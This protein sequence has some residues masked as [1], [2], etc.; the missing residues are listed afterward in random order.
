[1]KK[2]ILS[3]MRPT[4]KLHLGN[5]FGAL[6][7]W[8]LL[9]N[10]GYDCHFFVADWHAITTKHDETGGIRE[11]SIAMVKDWL[12]AGLDPDKSTIFVQSLVK[13]HAELFTILAMITPVG[14]LERC[15]TYKEQ[16]EQLGES[17]TANYGFLGYPVLQA[18][19]ILMYDPDFVPVGEDQLP[20]LEITREIARR[21]NFLYGET[22]KEPQA[23]LTEVPKLPGTD[24]RKMSKSYGNVIDLCEGS[25]ELWQKTRMM[26]T[27][28]ARVRKTDPGDPKLCSVFD[29]HKLFSPQEQR[30]EVC[31][32]CTGATIGCMD[33]KK[34][35]FAN[36]DSFIAPMRERRAAISDQAALDI[37]HQGSLRAAAVAEAHMK[38]VR[39]HMSLEI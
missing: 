36:L 21:F 4:G 8:V 37:M 5:Y 28:P 14:W 31:A 6:Q 1:M 3:G 10:E 18:A 39:S 27:D 30:D 23:K 35:L 26:V 29:F 2:S 9:Q 22:F 13:Q 16:K 34:M 33:C 19:D 7:N 25:D 38:R 20:H 15:P 32:G 12:A 24:G 17:K 11:N